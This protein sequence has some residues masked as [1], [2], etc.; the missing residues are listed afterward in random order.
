MKTQARFIGRTSVAVGLVLSP[1]LRAE[2]A[3]G[4]VDAPALVHLEH[5]LHA[6]AKQ[7]QS[8]SD[9]TR[10]VEARLRRRVFVPALE[11]D[12]FAQVRA[13]REK[14]RYVIEVRL[15]DREGRL[16]GRR[17]LETGARHCSALDDSLALVLSLAAD[18]PRARP[19]QA[20]PTPPV[21]KV[22]A[23]SSPPT[24]ATAV[25]IPAATHSPRLSFGVQPSLGVAVS[26]GL[27]PRLGVG[28]QARLQLR[29]PNFWPV[30]LNGTYWRGQR[31][32]AE[33]GA[34]FA[35]R[36]LQL[37]I[38]P[39]TSQLGRVEVELCVDQ[40]IGVV[41]ATGFGFD[42]DQPTERWLAALGM[43]ASGRYPAGPLFLS[44][45]GSLL[46]P[47]VQRRYFFKDGVDVTL[48]QGPWLFGVAVFS[49][50]LDL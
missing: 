19:E 28:A 46:V 41:K 50:G 17:R 10:A 43:G 37:W 31:L 26:A 27:L 9:L 36:T 15:E 47:L 3:R 18:V 5:V 39:W 4:G 13:H 33:A 34:D 32:G 23:S 14:A 20:G 44:V 2:V 8:A 7:C 11:A 49:L 21:T 16:L 42:Q 40:L 22:P 1:G 38:C 29:P 30:V 12:L 24:L 35:L 45:S 6:G 25:S 48:H